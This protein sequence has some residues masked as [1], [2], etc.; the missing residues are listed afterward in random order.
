MGKITFIS[1]GL[2]MENCR[3]EAIRELHLIQF[4]VFSLPIILV[5]FLHSVS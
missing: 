5:Q 3:L 2:N 1:K 4:H